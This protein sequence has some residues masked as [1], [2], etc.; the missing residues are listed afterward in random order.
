MIW[1]YTIIYLCYYVVVFFFNYT[2]PTEIYPY[3]HTLSQH[4]ALPIWHRF[5]G[6]QHRLL[7]R[8]R[9]HGPD[10]G[11]YL[12]RFQRISHHHAGDAGAELSGGGARG[13]LSGGIC[14][15]QSLDRPDRKSVV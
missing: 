12:G 6:F 7:Y 9:R 15:A 14:A 2:A 13:A 4:D 11:G 3:G 10:A 5:D 8:K 1:I